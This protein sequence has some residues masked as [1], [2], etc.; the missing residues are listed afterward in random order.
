MVQAQIL[1]EINAKFAIKISSDMLV[2]KQNNKIR[3]K[4]VFFRES[5]RIL[6]KSHFDQILL[7]MNIIIDISLKGPEFDFQPVKA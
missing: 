6:G 3:V 2:S 4:G 1:P 5:A 7:Q